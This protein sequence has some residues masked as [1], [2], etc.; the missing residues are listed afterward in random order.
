LYLGFEFSRL[1]ISDADF[2]CALNV[3]EE[4]LSPLSQI[5]RDL[6]ELLQLSKMGLKFLNPENTKLNVITYSSR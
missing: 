1:E 5:K 4:V 2:A 6:T 3:P